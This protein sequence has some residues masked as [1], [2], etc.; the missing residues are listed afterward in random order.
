[1]QASGET[2]RI[3]YNYTK[4]AGYRAFGQGFRF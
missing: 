4:Q 1:M 2:G 3:E